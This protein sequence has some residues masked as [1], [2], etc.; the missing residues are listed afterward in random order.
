MTALG[1]LT[2]FER[3]I[4]VRAGGVESDHPARWGR[5]NG[6][7]RATQGEELLRCS[8]KVGGREPDSF[9]E[10]IDLG[11]AGGPKLTC[12][13]AELRSTFWRSG[14]RR[15]GAYLLR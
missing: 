7:E 2:N 10:D 8:V 4:G 13:R 15:T 12:P 9:G 1:L 5:S 11:C 14:S 3:V 6:K